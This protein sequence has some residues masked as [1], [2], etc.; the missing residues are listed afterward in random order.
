MMGHQTILAPGFEAG[1]RRAGPI[2][3]RR[4]G[5][6]LTALV[7]SVGAH[8]LLALLIAL[9]PRALPQDARPQE[10]GTVELLMVEKKGAEPSQ[11][12]QPKDS[13]PT[14][15]PAETADAPKVEAQNNQTQKDETVAP[16]SKA[17]QAPPALKDGDEPVPPSS[18]E[19]APPKAAASDGGPATK[20]AEA[21][22]T[23]PRSQQGPVFKL[24]GTD[25][26]SNAIV[27]GGRVLPAM[28][29]DRFRNRPPV[30]PVEAEIR[31]EHGSVVVVIHVSENGV[32][33][34]A[35]VLESSGYTLL[36]RAAVDAVRKWR[37]HPAMK[38][39]RSIPFDMPFRFIFEAY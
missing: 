3:P 6:L 28:K 37:F 9:L 8:L 24:G 30:Y 7:L 31:G 19:Q 16:E 4:S 21:G 34:G 32:A 38:E 17:A 15:V 27:L 36:D 5:L 13:R 20:Q 23:P 26:E 14:P 1:R 11:A 10:E 29:D 25:S 35:H 2:A 18:T 12:G 39:G 33:T 22:A